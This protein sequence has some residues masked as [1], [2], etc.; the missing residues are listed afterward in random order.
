MTAQVGPFFQKQSAKLSFYHTSL[1]QGTADATHSDKQFK[2]WINTA[3]SVFPSFQI[4]CE[5]G[6]HRLRL[7]NVGAGEGFE[8]QSVAAGTPLKCMTQRV[9]PSIE[10]VMYKLPR[11]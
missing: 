6:L 4:K 11:A 5:L 3:G 9:C 8:N 10:S 1:L 7:A 2:Y